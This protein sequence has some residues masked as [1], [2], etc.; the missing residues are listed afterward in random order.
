MVRLRGL[1]GLLGL[2]ATEL[3]LSSLLDGALG[4]AD[5]RDTLDGVLAEVSTV[6]R[7]GGLVGNSLVGPRFANMSIRILQETLRAGVC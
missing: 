6:A 5:G 7:L 3:G 2:L 4:A 1:G